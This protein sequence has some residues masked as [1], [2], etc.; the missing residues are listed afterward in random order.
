MCPPLHNNNDPQVSEIPAR[1]DS[2]VDVAEL[3]RGFASCCRNEAGRA[4]KRV[5]L[6]SRVSAGP[7][8]EQ[9]GR[10]RPRGHQQSFRYSPRV[11]LARRRAAPACCGSRRL[12]K[13]VALSVPYVLLTPRLTVSR[14]F[15]STNSLPANSNTPDCSRQPPYEISGGPFKNGSPD[16]D[17]EIAYTYSV[18]WRESSTTFAT[19]WDHYLRVFDP[20]IHALSL[21][22]SVVIA[23]FRKSSEDGLLFMSAL[24]L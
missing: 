8:S 15:C 16:D 17:Q 18:Y 2:R 13:K 12:A 22:N 14:A 20:R 23:L 7:D 10:T 6:L 1:S 9:T 21:V 19:R 24:T 3:A 5:V 4:N 11:S